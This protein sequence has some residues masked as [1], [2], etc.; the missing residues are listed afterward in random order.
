MD[1]VGSWDEEPEPKPKRTELGRAIVGLFLNQGAPL[2]W[3]EAWD[4]V[5]ELLEPV[6]RLNR[7]LLAENNRLRQSD[8]NGK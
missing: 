6:R 7:R 2:V 5:E 8:S 4:Q 3:E 1:V